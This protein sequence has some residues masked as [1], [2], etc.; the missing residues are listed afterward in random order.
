MGRHGRQEHQP[1][2]GIA[3]EFFQELRLLG[4]LYPSA[5]TAS[6]KSWARWISAWTSMRWLSLLGNGLTKLRSIFMPSIGKL[7]RRLS[8]E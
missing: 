7:T 3:A 6:F 4:R 1:L 2:N 8:E 5:I